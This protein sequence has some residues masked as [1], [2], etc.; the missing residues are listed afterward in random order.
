VKRSIGA[1]ILSAVLLMPLILPQAAAETVR[2]RGASIMPTPLQERLARERGQL[3][4]EVLGAEITGE[5]YRPP[6]D[7]PFP[8]VVSLHGC[9]GRSSPEAEE[10]SG[11]RYVERGYV[12]LIVD[13][14]GLRGIIGRCLGEEGAAIDRTMDAYGALLYLAGSPFID[15]E[16][17]AV[18]GFS[19]GAGAALAAVALGGV[20]T[21][22]EHH[23]RA[24]IPYYPW[25]GFSTGAVSVPTLILIGELDDW[26]PAQSCREMM[27]RRSGGKRVI[28]AGSLPRCIS[29]LQ[30]A[31]WKAGNVLRPP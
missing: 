14:F 8:A 20:E 25:C 1:A 17:I 29:C 18:I 16:R 21:L 9:A 28:A 26:T 3:V 22:F 24:A 31:A 11:A 23:F 19:Q 6:G 13:S 7:G 15:S 27:A 10:A 2:F 4:R 5:L 30:C 12:L